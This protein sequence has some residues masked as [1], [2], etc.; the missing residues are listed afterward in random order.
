MDRDQRTLGGEPQGDRAPD[1]ARAARHQ[2][3]PAVQ[4]LHDRLSP[5]RRPPEG[6]PVPTVLNTFSIAR[7]V[8]SGEKTGEWDSPLLLAVGQR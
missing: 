3:G 1:P 2:C 6:R 5:L 7:Y 8:K 4:F